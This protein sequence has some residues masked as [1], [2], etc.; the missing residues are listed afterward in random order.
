MLWYENFAGT[1]KVSW[2]LY[3]KLYQVVEWSRV[4]WK[5]SSPS[6]QQR[7]HSFH[8][9]LTNQPTSQ[10]PNQTSSASSSR[11]YFVITSLSLSSVL[12]GDKNHQLNLSELEWKH[13]PTTTPATTTSWCKDI[14]AT[15]PLVT[16]T[17]LWRRL[18]LWCS[19]SRNKYKESEAVKMHW[20]KT[21]KGIRHCFIA[22]RVEK[23]SALKQDIMIYTL[24]QHSPDWVNVA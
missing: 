19:S 18:A 21:K 7:V 23:M 13:P 17:V 4:E 10:P 16:R 24:I 15:P 2:T 20:Q 5:K 6:K 9:L 8:P 3:R 12:D 1:T 22:G 14:R 11:V